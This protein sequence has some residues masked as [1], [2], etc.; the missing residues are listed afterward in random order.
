[1]ESTCRR[2]PNASDEYTTWAGVLQR[3]DTPPVPA[4][5]AG[6]VV[7]RDGSRAEAGALIPHIASAGRIRPRLPLRRITDPTGRF[8]SS[9]TPM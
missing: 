8:A 3:M 9:G 1:M 2:P 7:F 4:A 6:L 5:D